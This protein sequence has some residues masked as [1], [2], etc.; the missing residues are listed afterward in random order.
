MSTAQAAPAG[1]ATA[2]R[3]TLGL[4]AFS[5]SVFALP[6]A[7]TSAWVAAGG[8]PDPRTLALIVL[9]AVAARTAAMAFNRLV[10][11]DLDGANPRTANR[12]L[13]RGALSVGSVRALVVGASAVFI[14]GAVALN[15]LAGGLSPVVLAVVLGYSYTK[16]FTSLAHLVLG[17]ALGLAPLGA[18]IAVRGDFAGDLWIPLLL[19]SAVLTWV[20]GFDLIY[21]CQDARFDSERGLHSIPARFGVARALGLS[22]L[23]HL[24]TV[25]LLAGFA[26]RAGLGPGYALTLGLASVLLLWQHRIVSPNDLS[27]VDRAFFT[28]NGWVGVVLF[29]GVLADLHWLG[30]A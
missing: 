10:D 3:N 22:S 26:W 24:A 29:A 25:A 12:E 15:P 8:L 30:D 27:R 21:A 9:C 19:A 5:H 14:A 1:A 16:R 6:F 18:W 28:L 13:P 17:L 11:R 23:L 4:V 20:A 7:L 2:V